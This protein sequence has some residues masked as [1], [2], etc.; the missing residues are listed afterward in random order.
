MSKFNKI[1][2]R[3]DAPSADEL[4]G[5]NMKVLNLSA[6]IMVLLAACS[7][8]VHAAQCYPLAKV[9]NDGA[10]NS[11][12]VIKVSTFALSTGS[13]GPVNSPDTLETIPDI[14]APAPSPTPVPSSPLPPAPVSP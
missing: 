10:A 1:L 7:G 8:Q 12:E 6:A 5:R 11:G 13:L 3:I 4:N 2:L 9:V 14:F